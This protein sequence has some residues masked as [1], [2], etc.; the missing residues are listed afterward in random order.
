M[1]FVMKSR[2]STP[3]LAGVLASASVSAFAQD[4]SPEPAGWSFRFGPHIQFNY[5]T[6]I[7]DIQTPPNKTPGQFDN[8]F[9]KADSAANSTNT[10][11]W[12]YSDISGFPATVS[13]TALTL[14]RYDNVPRASDVT[15]SGKMAIGGELFAA[16]ELSTFRVWRKKEAHV[17]IELGYGFNSF[18]SS[19]SSSASGTVAQVKSIFGLAPGVTFFPP[20][21]GIGAP[22]VDG[23]LI[24]LNPTSSSTNLFAGVQNTFAA[25]TSVD[26][27]AFKLGPW[28]DLP[29][30]SKLNL[31]I[32]AGYCAVFAQ[33]DID[34]NDTLTGVT[35]GPDRQPPGAYHA[36]KRNWEPG[37]YGQLRLEY[38]FTERWGAYLGAD[39]Q[40]NQ[41]LSFETAGRK[42]DIQMG[43]AFGASAGVRFSF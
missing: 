39:F 37:M 10:W 35:L 40:H 18:E 33:A 32:G 8:G 6:S 36:A 30:T 3:L 22:T 5:K 31:H 15:G 38:E 17:G 28:I 21:P 20:S 42:F 25:K 2:I 7:H 19:T 13:G 29:L 14:T 27:N 16:Y 12:G 34:A 1:I 41:N 23:P 24:S 4:D 26:L 9:V 11:N 43:S